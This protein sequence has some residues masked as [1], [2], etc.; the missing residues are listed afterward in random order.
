MVAIAATQAACGAGSGESVAPA[1]SAAN[2]VTATE[3]APRTTLKAPGDGGGW[4]AG[5][6]DL[7][8]LLADGM[9]GPQGGTRPD[10]GF[11]AAGN[12]IAVWQFNCRVWGSRLDAASGQWGGAF[13]LDGGAGD[14]VEPV[15]ACVTGEPVIDVRPDGQALVAWAR[16]EGGIT[17]IMS[18]RLNG[19]VWSTEPVDAGG[20]S[21]ADVG[22]LAIAT[23]GQGET[24]LAFVGRNTAV[25]LTIADGGVLFVAA[26]RGA[27]W[28]LRSQGNG[29]PIG[30]A[31]RRAPSLV[32]D[33]NGTLH[34]IYP[35]IQQIGPSSV[36]FV[37]GYVP[38][39]AGSDWPRGGT[40]TPASSYGSLNS[41]IGV[42]ASGLVTIVLTGLELRPG[43][44]ARYARVNLSTQSANGGGNLG[45]GASLVAD[46]PTPP[47]YRYA[48]APVSGTQWYVGEG[49]SADAGP[50]EARHRLPGAADWTVTEFLPAGGG[51]ADL[52][53]A[54]DGADNLM[55]TYVTGISGG[56]GG[57]VHARRW[58]ASSGSWGPD[59]VIWP[60][61]GDCT[62]GSH[63]LKAD[64]AGRVLLMCG[65]AFST[66]DG[67]IYTARS[68]R[69]EP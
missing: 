45:P 63:R 11:D 39:P 25:P 26:N 34:L 48:V 42:D 7:A 4:D 49:E 60:G 52:Q 29:G 56:G 32:A 66:G 9:S 5:Y 50:V 37:T 1:A 58:Q 61:A 12:V 23:D 41:Q 43:S 44:G 16:T 2:N 35:L 22:H 6:A 10:F 21:I 54:V 59:Q 57:S 33:A 17:Q 53:T 36:Q 67:V 64:A 38:K 62:T 19:G 51:L 13:M 8:Y 14:R 55:V 27:G 69:F 40:A 15:A 68:R 24:S 46:A 65:V 47:R 30:D 3:A 31:D 18:A 20:L 28:T